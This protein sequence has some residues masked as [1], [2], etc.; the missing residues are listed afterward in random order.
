MFFNQFISRFRVQYIILTDQNANFESHMFKELF[1]LLNI[2]KT[3]TSPYHRQ[4][5]GQVERINRTLIELFAL[6]VANPTENW[7]L[8]VGLVLIAYRSVVQSSTCFTPHFMLV[9]REMQLPLD[10]MY[11]PPEASHT[12][13]ATR[14]RFERR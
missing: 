12:R 13:F 4:C 7:D 3:R 6:N 11:R 10:V 9:G 2:K 14:T 1:Q 5:D 8:N